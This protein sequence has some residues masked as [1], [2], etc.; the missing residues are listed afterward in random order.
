MEKKN[1]TVTKKGGTLPRV[2][3]FA[4]YHS[5]L[6]DAYE[7]SIT[8]VGPKKAQSLNHR[9]RKKKYTPNTLAFPITKTSGEIVLCERAARA[10]HHTFD[11]PYQTYLT[12]LVIHSMLHLKGYQHGSTM[13][14]VE[15]RLLTLF[16][17]DEKTRNKRRH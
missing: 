8:F 17:T 4:L 11:L 10:E 3:F 13:E 1:L 7:L 9:Y 15:K 5:I 14:R 16:T 12:Y 6:G 2:P